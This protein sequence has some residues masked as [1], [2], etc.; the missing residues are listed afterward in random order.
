MLG[1]VGPGGGA[2]VGTGIGGPGV[3]AGG[4]P[5]GAG[6]TGVFQ[7]GKSELQALGVFRGFVSNYRLYYNN[8]IILH[9]T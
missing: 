4:L 3:G 9:F 7:L 6:G 2:V 1:G 8:V 5:L